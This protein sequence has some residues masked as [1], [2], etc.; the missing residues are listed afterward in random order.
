VF[1]I[2]RPQ[3][4][5][6]AQQQKHI[7]ILHVQQNKPNYAKINFKNVLGHLHTVWPVIKHLMGHSGAY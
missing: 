4:A 3:Q 2:P 6:E 1:L 5:K 7:K